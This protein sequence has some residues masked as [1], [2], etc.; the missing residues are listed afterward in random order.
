M[1]ANGIAILAG[2]AIAAYLLGAVPFAL[3]LGKAIA[4]T[5]VRKVGSGSVGATNLVRVA[6]WRWGGICLALDF[7]KGFLPAVTGWR[8]GEVLDVGPD[9]LFAI[10]W[11]VAAIIG[12]IFPVYLRFKGGKGVATS[13]GVVTA[14]SP[15]ATGIALIVWA[16]TVAVSRYISLGSMLAA[17]AYAI[18]AI[19]LSRG[20]LG[21]GLVVTCFA[22][23]LPLVIIPTHHANIRRLLTGNENKI[24]RRHEA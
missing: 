21:S 19:A 24:G 22:I 18:T 6:G 8:L 2:G 14:V 10:A 15:I 16:V 3:I 7:L 17:S 4:K 1:G 11:G 9:K 20:R 5:D 13:F 12:H 23:L